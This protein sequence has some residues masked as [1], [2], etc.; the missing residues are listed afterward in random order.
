MY[1]WAN[2][3]FMTTALFAVLFRGIAINAGF[4]VNAA[5]RLTGSCWRNRRSQ[6][7]Q[8]DATGAIRSRLASEIQIAGD[9]TRAVRPDS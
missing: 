3:V 9:E 4:A 1:D 2:S 5:G 6:D 7:H 8:S